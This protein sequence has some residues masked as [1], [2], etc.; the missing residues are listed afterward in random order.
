MAKYKAKN[1]AVK[2]KKNKKSKPV[3]VVKGKK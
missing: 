1:K 3:K 2:P